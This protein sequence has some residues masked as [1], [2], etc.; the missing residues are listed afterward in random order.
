MA[1]ERKAV[2]L[3]KGVK[4]QATLWGAL[5][6][7]IRSTYIKMY[8]SASREQAGIRVQRNHAIGEAMR[9]TDSDD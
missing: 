3:P 5:D 8:M 7:T 1:F 6:P 9:S 4:T 2:K